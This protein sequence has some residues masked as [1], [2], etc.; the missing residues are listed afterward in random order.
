MERARPFQLPR[1]FGS[2]VNSASRGHGL[3][4]PR[5]PLR[6]SMG[7]NAFIERYLAR[8][9]KW[10]PQKV[11]KSRPFSERELLYIAAGDVL[12]RCGRRRRGGCGGV[13]APRCRWCR[14]GTPSPGWCRPRGWPAARNTAP[15]GQKRHPS[16]NNN[17]WYSQTV[18]DIGPPGEMSGWNRKMHSQSLQGDFIGPPLVIK[19]F[20]VSVGHAQLDLV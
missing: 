9:A 19:P 5:V 18:R 3:R 12:A 7:P 8:G 13:F 10:T 2:P 15:K 20:S 11:I 14:A 16:P 1:A 6:S 17:L 4:G